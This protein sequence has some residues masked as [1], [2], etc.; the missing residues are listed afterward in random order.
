MLL[1]NKYRPRTLNDMVGQEVNVRILRNMVNSGNVRQ[2]FIFSGPKGSGKTSM[3]RIL[4][5]MLN[6]QKGTTSEPCLE[7]EYCL[8][9]EK[10]VSIG[11]I[12]MDAASNNG[13]DTIRKINEEATFSSLDMRYKIWIFDEAHMMTKSAWNAFLKNLEEPPPNVVFIIATTEINQ[14]P[15]TIQSRCLRFNFTNLTN[16]QV[17]MFLKKVCDSEK[18]LYEEIALKIISKRSKGGM[19]SALTDLEMAIMASGN[20]CVDE[21]I[22]MSITHG[23]NE[24]IT[25]FLAKSILDNNMSNVITITQGLEKQDVSPKDIMS[26]LIE[27]L[28]LIYSYQLTKQDSMFLFSNQ[29]DKQ[30]AVNLANKFNNSKLAEAISILGIAYKDLVYNPNSKQFLDV[31][32][33]KATQAYH[34]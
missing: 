12:E 33:H 26:N 15:E 5:K 16:D 21:N 10:S 20:N 23:F 27:F 4:S 18:V 14:I 25:Y 8:M 19:R 13:V 11:T 29:D 9:I 6:C 17:F 32:V 3:A 28:H 31:S 2:S 30:N 7:C 1:Y 34:C 22:A 24:K